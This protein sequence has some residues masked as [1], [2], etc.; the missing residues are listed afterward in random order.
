MIEVIIEPEYK[1]F[2]GAYGLPTKA[3]P[4]SAAYDIRATGSFM[5]GAWDS[6][7]MRT[8]LKIWI[9]D[10]K[11][12]CEITPRSGLAIAADIVLANTTGLIDSDYQGEWKIALYNRS[13][14]DYQVERGQRIA[15]M[16]F[17]AVPDEDTTSLVLVSK[18]A[19]STTRGEGGFGSTGK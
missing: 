14:V 3:T 16:K 13:D 4:G 6:Y 5:V 10:P 12:C 8:G 1:Q 11:L 7:V 19:A 9:K 18:F 15:Q 2:Y 17:V